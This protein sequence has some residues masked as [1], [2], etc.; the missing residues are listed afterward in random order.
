MSFL[1]V[2]GNGHQGKNG[3]RDRQ[4]GN[5]VVHCAV[6]RAENP[7]PIQHGMYWNMRLYLNFMCI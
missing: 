2:Y 1:P 3:S 7:V 5:K 4:V 6:S